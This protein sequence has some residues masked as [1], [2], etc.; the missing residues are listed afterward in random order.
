MTAR[1]VAYDALPGFS[2]LFRAYVA[3]DAALAPHVAHPDWASDDALRR[4]ADAATARP[5]DR[6]ALVAALRAQQPRWGPAPDADAAL[7]RLADPRAVAVV[8]GQQV[9]LFGGP[10][11]TLFKAATALALARRAEAVTGRPAVAVFWMATEDHDVAEVDHVYF[12]ATGLHLPPIPRAPGALNAGPAGRLVLP[13]AITATVEAA[14]RALPAAPYAAAVAAALRAAYAPGTTLAD[15]FGRLTRWL[16]AGTGLVLLDPDDPAL[17]ALAAP[18]L[19][20]AATEGGAVATVRAAGERLAAAGLHAQIPDPTPPGIFLL[21]GRGR[22]GLVPDGPDDRPGGYHVRITG[23]RLSTAE[24]ARIAHDDPARLSPSVTL[25]PT[26]QDLL[27]PTV[28]YVGG[29]GEVAYWLQLRGV[30]AWAGVPM[31]VV[32]PRASA[33]LLD[34]RTRRALARV[35]LA[36]EAV[37]GSADALFARRAAHD[38][39][40]DA[41]FGGARAALAAVATSRA[42][43]PTLDRSA[44]AALTKATRALDRLHEK[45]VRA[46]RRGQADLR[47]AAEH[48]VAHLRPGGVLQERVLSPLPFRARYG[49][50]F[51]AHL[52]DAL[53]LVPTAHAVVEV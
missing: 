44:A 38:P 24:L 48:V 40:L 19:A 29:P 42:L 25:R 46:E 5:R 49:P 31:P 27:L 15:A 9:S 13:D 50:A 36:P 12:G 33:T 17:K 43:D 28:A 3:G 20:R 2:A 37:A 23:A 26:M 10:L 4:A 1:P 22:L 7:D 35:G 8:T 53:P 21:D 34:A 45:A 6:A 14:A 47:R 30:Y 41:A 18:L 11:Y 52:V 51:V 32:Y 39:A 16:F